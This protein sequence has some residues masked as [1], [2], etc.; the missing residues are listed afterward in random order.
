MSDCKPSW[1]PAEPNFK[2]IKSVDGEKG[3]VAAK[4]TYRQ[5]VIALLWIARTYGPDILYDVNKLCSHYH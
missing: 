3:Y 2:F 5:T 4:F 1:T